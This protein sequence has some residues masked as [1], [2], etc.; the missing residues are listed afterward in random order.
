MLTA[1][2]EA[3]PVRGTGL[4]CEGGSV[5]SYL[6]KD[7]GKF[8]ESSMVTVYHGSAHV[9]E[10]PVFGFGK[11][12]NDYGRGFY[13]TPDRQLAG[14]WAVL[15]TGCDGCINEYRLNL[16]GLQILDLDKQGIRQWI[17]VLMQHRGGYFDDLVAARVKVFI[18]DNPVAIG[19]YDVIRGWR[20]DD[21]YFSIAAAYAAGFLDDVRLTS[22]LRL[23][24]LGIQFCIKTEAAFRSLSFVQAYAASASL[25]LDQAKARD[26]AARK[27]AR[28]V[29]LNAS[30]G[31]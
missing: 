17:S 16:A 22:L 7:M 23:G 11:P 31:L 30:K 29:I 4:A 18:E 12:Y 27:K 8:L 24:D 28:E 9:V 5:L 15:H 6:V 21:S 26:T 13:T 1:L 10:V 14:E 25:F 19:G 2:I 20:A 3:S